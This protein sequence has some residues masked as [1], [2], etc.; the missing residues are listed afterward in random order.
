[1]SRALWLRELPRKTG[2]KQ[3]RR[4]HLPTNLTISASRLTLSTR[5]G[6][7][8]TSALESKLSAIHRAV[9]V[10]SVRLAS[11]RYTSAMASTQAVQAMACHVGGRSGLLSSRRGSMVGSSLGRARVRSDAGVDAFARG[12]GEI[13]AQEGQRGRGR[14]AHPRPEAPA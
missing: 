10:P 9:I 14:G 8:G 1:M 7:L 2:N 6:F 12:V 3:P 11:V 13:I 5:G 4:F